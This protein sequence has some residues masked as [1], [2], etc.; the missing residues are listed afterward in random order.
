[1]E[2]RYKDLAEDVEWE[3]LDRKIQQIHTAP[4]EGFTFKIDTMR[5]LTLLKELCLETEAET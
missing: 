3:S 1:M 4:L 2:L 5:V